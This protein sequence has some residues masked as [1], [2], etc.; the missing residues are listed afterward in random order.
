MLLK[1][2]EEITIRG[3]CQSSKIV[4]SYPYKEHTRSILEK[5]LR[6]KWHPCQYE[7]L[8]HYKRPPMEPAD[9]L[10]TN[11]AYLENANASR[12]LRNHRDAVILPGLTVEALGR[13]QGAILRDRDVGHILLIDDKEASGWRGRA[14][15]ILRK[16]LADVRASHVLSRVEH[17]WGGGRSPAIN[18]RRLFDEQTNGISPGRRLS[19]LSRSN[20]DDFNFTGHVIGTWQELIARTLSGI[21]ILSSKFREANCIRLDKCMVNS[22]V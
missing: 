8:G 21:G 20:R 2:L 15:P 16:Y 17:Q 14:S 3:I 13:V 18:G 4:I 11:K 6:Q 22:M 7:T 1:E 5:A 12:A 10:I 19:D 9:K